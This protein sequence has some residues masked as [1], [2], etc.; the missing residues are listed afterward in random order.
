[1]KSLL[2]PYVIIFFVITATYTTA[3]KAQPPDWQ[4]TVS[5][6][7]LSNM[8][9]FNFNMHMIHKSGASSIFGKDIYKFALL[10]KDSTELNIQ[11]KVY[12]DTV[13]NKNYLVYISRNQKD[14][15]RRKIVYPDQ[16][17]LIEQY[18]LGRYTVGIP[19]DSCWLFRVVTGKI[20]AFAIY[21]DERMLKSAHLKAIQIED[22]PIE[23]IDSE[24]LKSVFINNE[25]ALEALRQNDL[26]KAI[27]RYNATFDK[28]K[29]PD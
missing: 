23:P 22:G 2:K 16:T 18:F 17:V 14:K 7:Q 13:T 26:L 27:K 29:K 4:R 15:N 6:A 10:L 24:K 25:K 21:P 28:T 1:M 5:K 12:F 3:V 8:H 11:S 9:M 19:T 20:N